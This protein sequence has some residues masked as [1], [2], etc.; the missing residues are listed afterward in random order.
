[1]AVLVDVLFNRTPTPSA[2]EIID[3]QILFDTSG[4]GKMYLDNGGKRL[5]MGGA[6]EI[7]DVLKKTSTNAIQNRAVAGV[8]LSTLSDIDGVNSEGFLTDALGTK[9]LLAKVKKG[10]FIDSFDA[11]SGVLTTSSYK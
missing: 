8:M 10:L 1:M 3:G 7:D 6:K 5:E 11:S 9:N 2:E 4:N